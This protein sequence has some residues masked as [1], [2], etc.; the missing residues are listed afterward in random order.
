MTGFEPLAL[1]LKQSLNQQSHNHGILSAVAVVAFGVV[2]YSP[3]L[4]Y[5][6]SQFHSKISEWSN[7]S[8]LKQCT[9]I[10]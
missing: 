5:F 1:A 10:G 6:K 7:Y 9:L 3:G 4:I 2:S 8:I